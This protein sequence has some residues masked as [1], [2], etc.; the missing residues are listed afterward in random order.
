MD[1]VCKWTNA[2]GEVVYNREWKTVKAEEFK[3]FIGVTILIGVC[4]SRSENITQPWSKHDGR[5]IFNH[6]MSRRRYQQI[7]RVLRF[8]DA[9]ERRRNRYLDK[10]QPIKEVF[11]TWESYLR[12]AYISGPCM[13]VDEQLLCFRGR[14]PFRQYIPSK[15]GKYVI[16][17]WTICDSKTFYAWK[18]HV[19][20]GKNDNAPREVNQGTLFS[21]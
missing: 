15:P 8:D 4:K 16:K 9:K 2:E 14:C 6:I 7:L 12:D 3:K 18:M 5:P 20:M 1:T 19:Y 17:I 21:T 10:L 13:K 11:E